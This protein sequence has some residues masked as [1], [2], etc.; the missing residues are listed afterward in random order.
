M[1]AIVVGF[2][3]PACRATAKIPICRSVAKLNS[4]VL[5]NGWYSRALKKYNSS[6]FGDHAGDCESKN[7]GVTRRDFSSA[8]DQMWTPEK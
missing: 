6:P 5:I 7:S 1:F 4:T 3:T 8:T 2:A